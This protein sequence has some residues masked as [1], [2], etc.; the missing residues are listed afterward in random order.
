MDPEMVGMGIPLV[1]VVPQHDVRP[2][3]PHH[4]HDAT[5]DVVERGSHEGIGMIIVRGI[6]HAGVAVPEQHDLVV[7]DDRRGL[8][9]LALAN[10][11]EVLAHRRRLHRRIEDVPR[12]PPGGGQQHRLHPGIGVP[13]HRTRPFGALIVRMGMQR[14]E[15]VVHAGCEYRSC[16]TQP[17]NRRPP[18]AAQRNPPGTPRPGGSSGNADRRVAPDPLQ[19]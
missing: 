16:G 13:S 14:Q 11:A 7:P 6:G 19:R 18:P 9:E 3:P 4:V 10:R 17:V 8:L 2:H 12:L 1:V 15:S 5:Q